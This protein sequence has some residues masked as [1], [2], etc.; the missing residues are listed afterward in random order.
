MAARAA[1]R[2][3]LAALAGNLRGGVALLALRR[4]WP[5]R[6]G[7]SFDQVAALLAVNLAVWALLD[8]LHD[9]SGAPLA[10]DGLFG[11]ACYLLLGLIACA[12]VARAQSRDAD[13]RALLVPALAVAPWALG[14]LWLAG[15]LPLVQ[16]HPVAFTVVALVYLTLLLRRVLGAAFAVAR[17]RSVLLGCVLLLTGAW[18]LATLNLDTRLWVADTQADGRDSDDPAAVE[19]LFYDQP[20]RLAAAME[21]VHPT[22]P[23]RPGVFFV[24]FAGDG[25]PAV[26]RREALFAAQAFG[27]RYDAEDR[28]VLLVNDVHDRDSF[29]LASVTALDATLKQ[30]GARMDAQQDVLVLFLT[31]HGSPDGLE[32]ANGTLPLGQLEPADLR[33]MLDDAGIRWRVIIISA[34]YAGVFIDALQ[35]DS[36]AVITASDATHTSFGCQDDRDLTWFGQAFLKDALPVSLSLE[37]AFGRAQALIRQ[38]ES[39]EHEIHSN[40]QFIMGPLLRARLAQIEGSQGARER[41]SYSVSR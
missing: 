3:F 12:L 29:P 22:V 31:S 24:G 7:V 28:S 39:A 6:F 41:T 14:A 11:W 30:L 40:P 5:P 37:E 23:G 21:R 18:L 15:D 10:L 26:F 33:Q 13:T 19:A 36:T 17:W 16:R 34:C 8:R 35:D 38:R 2:A 4:L 20:A 32:V 27:T 25:D 1:P 9:S